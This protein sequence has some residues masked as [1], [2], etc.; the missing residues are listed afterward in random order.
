[1][2]CYEGINDPLLVLTP[3]LLWP[4]QTFSFS[5]QCWLETGMESLMR[6]SQMCVV[7]LSRGQRGSS[8]YL[9]LGSLSWGYFWEI[10]RPSLKKTSSEFWL[11]F[12]FFLFSPNV[13]CGGPFYIPASWWNQD[14]ET[15][16]SFF[17]RDTKK[18][19]LGASTRGKGTE[20]TAGA[21]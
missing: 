18:I 4:S 12:N 2:T 16:F 8:V 6:R 17:Q 19:T 20:G 1:M 11:I 15:L 10:L 9:S 7:L 3:S 14:G 13:F 21:E 5:E